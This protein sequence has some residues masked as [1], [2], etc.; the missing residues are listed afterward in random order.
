MNVGV[1]IVFR[2]TWKFR[3]SPCSVFVPREAFSSVPW[4]Q[5]EGW[6]TCGVWAA[7]EKAKGGGNRQPEA[8][9]A[10]QQH[11]HPLRVS[12]SH[13]TFTRARTLRGEL[14]SYLVGSEPLPELV[15]R[16]SR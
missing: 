12:S 16:G 4:K 9:W 7:K 2:T 11:Q 10:P 3:V 15:A 6:V 14:S 5:I 8:V 13:T 1:L